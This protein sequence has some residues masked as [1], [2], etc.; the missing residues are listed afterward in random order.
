MKRRVATVVILAG[1]A[2][3]GGRVRGAAP[4]TM[5][6]GVPP[7][8]QASGVGSALDAPGATLRLASPTAAPGA[9]AAVSAM[10]PASAYRGQLVRVSGLIDVREAAGGASVWI[11]ADTTGRLLRVVSGQD[12]RVRGTATEERAVT[13]VVPPNATVLTFG[14]WLQGPG[15][16]VARNLRLTVTQPPTQP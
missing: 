12:R 5:E 16:A 1:I 4:G 3:C 14:L 13:L 7:G 11:R 15:V 10:V 2:G 6:W 8:Y 9:E